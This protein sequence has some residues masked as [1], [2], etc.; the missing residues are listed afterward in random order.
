MTDWDALRLD[1][2]GLRNTCYLNSCSMGLPDD[3]TLEALQEYAA[4][5]SNQGAAS[6][7]DQWV[8]ALTEWRRVMAGLI[9]ARSEEIAWAPSAGAA[10][11]TLGS[12]LLRRRLLQEGTEGHADRNE[13]VLGELEFPAAYAALGLRPGTVTRQA[14]QI[15]TGGHIPAEN[16][17][18]LFGAQ[19]ELLL[20][21]RVLYST[22]ALQD[23]R[24]LCKSAREAGA[25]SI[26]DDY[27][28]LGQLSLDVSAVA[29]DAAVGGSLKWLCGGVASAWLFVRRDIIKELEP[30]HYGWWANSAMFEFGSAFTPWEDARRFEGGEV[31]VPGLLTS[32]AAAQRLAR[33]G[34]GK[35]ERRVR[36]LAR[37]L[38]E[39]LADQGVPSLGLPEGLQT[40]IVAIPRKDAAGDTARLARQ[41]IVVDHRAGMLRVSPHYY[42]NPE[43]HDRLL[44]LLGERNHESA[45]QGN[46]T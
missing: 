40:G 36:E 26:V 13:L 46:F 19:S 10:L 12:A 29:P 42:N 33:I 43:D 31:N 14:P 9:G 17:E 7:A 34:P 41:G 37:D 30:M 44:K 8:D 15:D 25:F 38:R 1:V 24:R 2:P 23:V 11:G 28:G 4:A 16:Y 45:A 5:W 32:L 27:Q 22:G 21:S 35:V 6:W 18:R 3:S 39:R 20:A